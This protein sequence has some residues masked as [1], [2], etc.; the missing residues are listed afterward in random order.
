MS[1]SKNNSKDKIIEDSD[2]EFPLN[3]LIPEDQRKHVIKSLP[4]KDKHDE[5]F[6]MHSVECDDLPELVTKND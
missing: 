5:L 2:D 3:E 4:E 6:K 1:K